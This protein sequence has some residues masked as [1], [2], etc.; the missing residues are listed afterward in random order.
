MSGSKISLND[1]CKSM[2]PWYGLPSTDVTYTMFS[3]F[4]YTI[5]A[6]LVLEENL[7]SVKLETLFSTNFTVRFHS[8]FSL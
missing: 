4:G 2:N 8:L 1:S 5:V 3:K 7:F 6:L